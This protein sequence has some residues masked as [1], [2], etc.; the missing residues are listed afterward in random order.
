[1]TY[2]LLPIEF[3]KN[4]FE[5]KQYWRDENYAIYKQTS[6]G[7]FIAYEVFRISKNDAWERFG[8]FFEAC[9]TVPSSKQWGTVAFTCATVEDCHE[10]VRNMQRNTK[11]NF[12]GMRMP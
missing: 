7:K 2:R 12:T 3:T 5:Y 6:S 10:K 9:E 8:R 11:I 4:T 1:M